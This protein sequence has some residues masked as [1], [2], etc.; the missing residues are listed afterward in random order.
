MTTQDA[1]PLSFNAWFRENPGHLGR[2]LPSFFVA[3]SAVLV[4]SFLLPEISMSDAF[5]TAS[6]VGCA[7]G[8]GRTIM[9][10]LQ[11]VIAALRP[12]AEPE[13]GISWINIMAGL[14]ITAML[15][16]ALIPVL[17]RLMASR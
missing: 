4:G 12:G 2:A 11:S 13:G 7:A 10:Y 6:L 5:I 17:A 15:M 8:A 1:R 3:F 14:A 16:T 9:G